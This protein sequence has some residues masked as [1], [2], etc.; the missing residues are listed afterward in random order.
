MGLLDSLFGGL[1]GEN[2]T[3]TEDTVQH[4]CSNC[5]SNCALAP[6]A[7][8]VCQPYKE[9]MTDAIYRVEHRDEIVSQYEVVGTSAEMGTVVCPHC[10][11]HSENRYK[12]DYCGSS[13]QEGSG[14]IQVAS[15]ADI[16]NPILEAQDLI[17][18]R[19]AAVREFTQSMSEQESGGFF[20]SLFGS[21]FGMDTDEESISVGKKMT[22]SEI[23]EMADYFHVSVSDYLTG[24][25]NGKYPTLSN[26]ATYAELENTT[27]EQNTSSS[28]MDMMS[29][30]AGLAGAIGLG[31]AILGGTSST[32]HGSNRPSS[33]M[34]LFGLGGGM[35]LNHRPASGSYQNVRPQ[36][37]YQQTPVRPQP[38]DVIPVRPKPEPRPAVQPQTA[39]KPRPSAKP[40]QTAKRPEAKRPSQAHQSAGNMAQN[41]ANAAAGHRPAEPKRPAGGK[42]GGQGSAK[43]GRK[44]GKL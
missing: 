41:I 5:P 16:P 22:E 1:F 38:Q 40:A 23:K 25:D 10:G 4:P 13:L 36:M 28:S 31:S 26:K 34:N 29:G 2:E 6:D 32:L 27:Y 33:G 11:G 39:N 17:F 35:N 9:K 43:S 30:L 15:A 20:S 21:L 24:L 3:T 12:C 37:Q 19:Q 14:K 18:E 7:C 44:G 42:I 8:S